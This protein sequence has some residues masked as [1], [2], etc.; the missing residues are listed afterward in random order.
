LNKFL[1][2]HQPFSRKTNF[3]PK[4]MLLIRKVSTFQKQTSF[5]IVPYTSVNQENKVRQAARESEPCS[6]QAFTTPVLLKKSFLLI[7]SDLITETKL[8]QIKSLEP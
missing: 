8:P 7:R 6:Q 5:L 3:R 2:A 1:K 4:Q